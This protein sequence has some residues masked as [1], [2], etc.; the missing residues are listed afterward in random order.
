MS[1]SGWSETIKSADIFP[2]GIQILF[3]DGTHKLKSHHGVFFGGLFIT[4]LMFFA[5][6][7]VQ[8]MLE[9]D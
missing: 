1:T 8:A 4:I 3:D 2:Q 6:M 7:K 5:T 9:Y